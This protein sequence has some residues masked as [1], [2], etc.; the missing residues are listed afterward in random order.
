MTEVYIRKDIMGVI[1]N[2]HVYVKVSLD[3]QG[4]WVV[5]K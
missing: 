4:K 1:D 5:V 3:N 2:K